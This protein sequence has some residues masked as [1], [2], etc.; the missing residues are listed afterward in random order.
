MASLK[1]KF[2]GR[3]F[4]EENAR[5]ALKLYNETG[6]KLPSDITQRKKGTGS[7]TYKKRSGRYQARIRKKGK[8]NIYKTFDTREECEE[9]LKTL[10]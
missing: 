6:E 7:V 4:T 1:G 10:T 3:Y 2:I 8:R 9:W 5:K